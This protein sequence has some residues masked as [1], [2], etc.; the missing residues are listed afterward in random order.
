MSKRKTELTERKIQQMEEEGHGTSLGEIYG[1]GAKFQIYATD[2]DVYIVSSYNRNWIIGRPVIYTV[3]DVFSG[4]VVG[5]YVG[6][7]GPS[8]QGAMMALEN[9][10]SNKVEFCKKFGIEI[11]E[12][13]W[14]SHH[15]PQILLTDCSELEGYNIE[16]LQKVFHT[17]VENTT[18]FRTDWKAIVEQHFRIINLKLKP[19]L[20]GVVD[21]DVRVRSDRD[22]HLDA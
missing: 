9:T 17:K 19:F 21:T 2:A 15:L 6:L 5:L 16:R 10:A 18:P 3:I 20:P 14:P 22:Y 7:E 12:E 13:E 8:W 11:T 1:P 4:M